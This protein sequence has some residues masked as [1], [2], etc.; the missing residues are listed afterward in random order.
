MSTSY[1][2][3]KH[4]TIL[5]VVTNLI[6][7]VIAALIVGMDV[8]VSG[9][10]NALSTYLPT[11]IFIT[12]LFWLFSMLII[13]II[14]ADNELRVGALLLLFISLTGLYLW[15][16]GNKGPVSLISIKNYL[17][18]CSSIFVFWVAPT[19]L[20]NVLIKRAIY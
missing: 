16:P 5:F 2:K 8:E 19:I 20:V 10:P 13:K 6:N 1:Q 12:V 9:I 15:Y 7:F 17:L 4:I 11:T 14:Q 18:I 3:R